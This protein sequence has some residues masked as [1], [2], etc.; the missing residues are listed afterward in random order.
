MTERRRQ[1]GSLR[2]RR[3]VC[4]AAAAGAARRRRIRG[5]SDA[6][7]ISARLRP[8]FCLA[9]RRDGA[10]RRTGDGSGEAMPLICLCYAW[11]DQAV[12]A[13]VAG[14]LRA[15]GAEIVAEAEAEQRLTPRQRG[16]GVAARAKSA[17]MVAVIASD[18]PEGR[19]QARRAVR[20]ALFY[21][22]RIVPARLDPS[23]DFEAIARDPGLRAGSPFEN[24][25]DAAAAKV[26]AV[27]DLRPAPAIDLDREEEAEKAA[28][29]GPPALSDAAMEAYVAAVTRAAAAAV[30][31]RPGPLDD[32]DENT[33]DSAGFPKTPAAMLARWRLVEAS[34]DLIDVEDFLIDY[35]DDPYF[36]RRAA[37]EIAER[38][39]AARRAVGA[40]AYR[41][42]VGVLV[43][44]A[45]VWGVSEAC[46]PDRCG[47]SA[48]AP[49]APET[50]EAA[51]RDLARARGER[52]ALEDERTRLRERMRALSE[53]R[54]A[55]KAALAS[56]GAPVAPGDAL[57]LEEARAR[58][59][60]QEREIA[61]LRAA[62]ERAERALAAARSEADQLR[63]RG[64]ARADQDLSA[65]LSRA[66]TVIAALRADLGRRD[67]R[68]ATMSAELD[69][70]KAEAARQTSYA[71]P[72]VA[73][74]PSEAAEAAALIRLLRVV[75]EELDAS[76]ERRI[77]RL[78]PGSVVKGPYLTREDVGAL[79]ACLREVTGE[80]AKVDGLWGRR[81][82]G[83]LMAVRAD[84][85][86]ATAACL[87]RRFQPR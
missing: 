48:L 59:A 45:L 33:T 13:E 22:K 20:A 61:E 55:L 26:F 73:L 72:S 63:G 28:P 30:A 50:L 23:V 62:Q 82:T 64:A 68:L 53:E 35:A 21:E 54:D 76:H 77:K 27:V 4:G 69:R 11:R 18:T 79:Q 15:A 25:S 38:R 74:S 1:E 85:A 67:A 6:L 17:D 41:A 52:R 9:V 3:R 2:A 19:A 24:Q 66:E 7:T 83:A 29:S 84:Q 46:G 16:D 44:G 75:K 78:A 14:R 42:V 70:L 40:T 87:R 81:T 80:P 34:R 36:S 71:A 58:I 39:A 60:R 86:D 8:A 43:A 65:E 49:A 47:L 31:E 5:F 56:A 32:F 37:E 12:A 10:Y 51:Q 57:A